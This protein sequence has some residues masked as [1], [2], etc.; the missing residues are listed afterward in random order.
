MYLLVLQYFGSKV[1]GTSGQIDGEDHTHTHTDTQTHAHAHPTTASSAAVKIMS[2][3]P[4]RRPT[5]RA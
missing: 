5:T 1:R 2:L 3:N 4:D